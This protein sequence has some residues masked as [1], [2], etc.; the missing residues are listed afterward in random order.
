M[1]VFIGF[2]RRRP[3]RSGWLGIGLPICAAALLGAAPNA[4]AVS[5]I[6]LEIGEIRLPGTQGGGITATLDLGTR[7]APQAHVR[8]VQMD[9]PAPIGTLKSIELTCGTVVVREPRF[10]CRDARLAA[11]GGPTKTIAMQAALEYNSAHGIT[12]VEGSGFAVAGG[13]LQFA[14]RIDAGG[15]SIE[16]TGSSLDLQQIRALATPWF[17]VPADFTFSG[18]IDLEGGAVS[19]NE[20]LA[21]N[22]EV[23]TADLDF[24]NEEG[25]LVAQKVATGLRVAAERAPGGYDIEARLDGT[26]GQALAGPVL[27]DLGANQLRLDTRGRWAGNALRVDDIAL[28]QNNLSE[29]HGRANIELGKTPRVTQAHLDLTNVLFP[30]A[31]TSFMQ[32]ALAATD[33]GQL[34][35]TGIAHGNL[36]IADNAV[37]RAQL[38]L[39]HV[40]LVDTQ[41]KFT[42]SDVNAGLNWV[43]DEQGSVE[44]SYLQWERASAYGLS[45]EG[46][47]LDFIT[48]AFGFEL[49]KPTRVPLFDGAI[50]VNKLAT[51]RL[52]ATD[53]ELLFDAKIEPIS[54]P[55][56]CRAFGWPEMS[57]Q[58]SGSIPGLTYKNRVLSVDGDVV[59]SV[60][61]GTIVG[62]NFR[63]QDPLGPWPRLFAD[64]TA[65]RLDLSLVTRTF[66]I[67]SITGRLDADIEHLELFNW[68]PVAFD[69]RLYS[70]P[71]DRSKKLIS[72]K[73]VTSISNVGGGGGRVT[74]ALQSGL[75]RFFDQFR[76]EQIGIT[77]KLENE[78]CLMGGIEPAGTGYYLVKGRGLPRIDIIGNQGRVAWPQLV[79]QLAN[80]IRADVV[81]T[82]SRPR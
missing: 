51:K 34:T 72:Q 70:T 21:L 55:L 3:C 9:L 39:S 29:V 17:K 80:S 52:G 54:M 22:A 15:W 44:P 79:R 45:G 81:V 57:G 5:R 59:A 16:G 74:A 23:R 18:H 77:C 25:T 38:Q 35:T 75:L 33:F 76:Y 8:A 48:R 56:L 63:L 7:G 68:S 65:R 14:S 20:N 60:F 71:G 47:R 28:V 41:G 53:A 42:M 13:T 50:V 31:Y 58:L 37:T 82:G 46:A 6:V 2:L 64:V 43:A 27:L 36:D 19:R 61:D 49:V 32:I 4:F 1:P 40:G 10:A 26:S 24:T 62:R 30:A 12:S 66:A 78:V 11:Q 69:A 67:G 73:A